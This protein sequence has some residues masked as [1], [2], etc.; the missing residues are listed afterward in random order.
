[1]KINL[2]IAM[3]ALMIC[4]CSQFTEHD[5]A[6]SCTIN[7]PASIEASIEEPQESTRTYVDND[8]TLHW[9]AND[10]ISYFPGVAVNMQYRFSG[11][12][13]AIGGSFD[14]VSSESVSGTALSCN[15]ALYPYDKSTSVAT[16]GS[17]SYT[18]PDVQYYAEES[19]GLGANV[20]VAA[21]KDTNDNVL[22]F[23]NACGYLEIQLYGTNA[24][25]KSITVR[26]NKDEKIA[27]SGQ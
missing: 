24:K 22:R 18:L 1:M 3:A 9:T 6:P 27:R 15:Y 11:E 17:I 26:G 12:T 16:N 19:F 10:E 5:A 25:V 21:T 20:M 13:G 23:K 2:F 4:G 7:A 14:R 8:N